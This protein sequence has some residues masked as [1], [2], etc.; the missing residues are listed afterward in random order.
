MSGVLS[1]LIEPI[2]NICHFQDDTR[3]STFAIF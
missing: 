2:E 3:L 1:I